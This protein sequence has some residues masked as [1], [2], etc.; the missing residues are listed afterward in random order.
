MTK[1]EIYLN[2][3]NK[4]RWFSLWIHQFPGIFKG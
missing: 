2:I 1:I 4:D 3:F